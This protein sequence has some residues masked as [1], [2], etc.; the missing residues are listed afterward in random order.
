MSGPRLLA[1][2][3]S[4]E[5]CSAAVRVGGETIERYEE[6]GSAQSER[7]LELAGAV[8]AEA[9]LAYAGLDAI[10]VGV[11]PGA[12]TG[13]RIGVA[14][15]QGLAFGAGLALLP[16]TTLE[17]L[18]AAATSQAAGEGAVLACLDARMAELYW[19]VYRPDVL[20]GVE[21][22]ASPRVGS[23]ESL[24]AAR[25]ACVRGLGRGFAAYPGLAAALGIPVEPADARRLP[26][27]ADLA[28]LGELR[29]RAGEALD[30]AAISPV[31]LRDKVAR[32][33]A[34]RAQGRP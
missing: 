9:G 16:V 19:G 1:L 17:M 32:T 28:W 11:G 14:L 6:P 26:R 20:R 4:T 29:L 12:F 30:P 13:V 18:A 31:Y 21:A 27:A 7:L 25:P 22:L 2:D 8:M 34:E 23:E 15:A 24:R 33:E 5:A 3:A 10:A